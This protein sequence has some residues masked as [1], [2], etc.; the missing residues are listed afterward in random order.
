[1]S[2]IDDLYDDL[3]EFAKPKSKRAQYTALE[4]RV[5][6]GFEDILRFHA[7]HG[8]APLHGESRDIFERTYAVRLDR[9]R[10]LHEFHELLKPLDDLGLLAQQRET[11]SCF[12]QEL[13]VDALAAEL[14]DIVDL[15]LIHI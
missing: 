4:E 11:E 7:S 6:A 10:A 13:D 1:M 8:R 2:E 5:I 9:L 3:S 15:S 12:D 14:D